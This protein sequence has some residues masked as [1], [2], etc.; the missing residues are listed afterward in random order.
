MLQNFQNLILQTFPLYGIAET[1]TFIPTSLF[2]IIILHNKTSI[3]VLPSKNQ[4]LSEYCTLV[5]KLKHCRYFN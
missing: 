3:N 2:S 5:S 1:M 4:V